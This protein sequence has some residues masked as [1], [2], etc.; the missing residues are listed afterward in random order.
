MRRIGV[1]IRT[2]ATRLWA[3]DRPLTAVTAI[4]LAALVASA[5]GFILD[6]RTIAGAPAWLKPAKFAVSAAIYAATLA[7]VFRYLSEWRRTRRIV[8]WT[9]AAVFVLEVAIID[10]QAWRG[11]TSHFNVSTVLDTI[12]FGIMGAAIAVQTLAA[13]A[14]AVALWRQRFA[15]AAIGWTLRAGMTLT[16]VG[17]ATGGLMTQPTEAQLA[18]ARAAQQM[19]VSGAHTV[20]APDGGPGLPGTGWSREH[21]D[22]RV[23]HFVGLHAMQALALIGVVLR[24]RARPAAAAALVRVAAAS[25]AALFAILLWQAISGESIAAP[26]SVTLG[27]LAAWLAMTAAAAGAVV[28]RRKSRVGSRQSV[29]VGSRESAVRSLQSGVD[30]SSRER[31]A[32]ASRARA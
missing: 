22:L 12:L 18:S 9:T 24:R 7:W 21:G 31:A 14:V 2:A 23:P 5:A 8:G 20:G 28:R 15:D 17:A 3:A 29:A 13:A 32:L 6:P 30:T 1:R 16:L 27:V 4:M 26:S 10:L 11:T 25:Y 19:R